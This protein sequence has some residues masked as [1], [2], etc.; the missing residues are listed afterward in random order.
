ME[1]MFLRKSEDANI[2][3]L[4]IVSRITNIKPIENSDKLST[5]I[6]NGYNIIV[7]NTTKIGDIVVF[8]PQESCIC[9]QFL[10]ANNEYGISDYEKNTNADEIKRLIEL[11]ENETDENKAKELM[12]EAKSKVGF[13]NKYGRVTMLK[14][15]GE[16]SFGFIMPINSIEKA[17]P[18]LVGTNW[19][20][21]VGT[22]FNYI[23]D[24]LFCWKY[25]PRVKQ[26]SHSTKG[27]K[28]SR[29]HRRFQ[30]RMQSFDRIIPE[31]FSRH[32]ETEQ[33]EKSIRDIKPDDVISITVKLH[34]QSGIFC[35]ILCNRQLTR[36]EKIKKFFGFDV[37]TTEYGN[38][39]SS[40][41]VIKNKEIN[42]NV[43][44]GY[45]E[46]D[47]WYPV[48][49]M[50]KPYIT[51]G[52]SVYGEVVGY[53]DGTERPIQPDHDYGCEIGEWKFLPY[54]IS[55][56]L[57]DGKKYEWNVIEVDEWT[58]KLLK[59]HPELSKNIIPFELLYHGK[60]KDLYPELDV[61]SE[62][63]YDDVLFKMKSEKKW[64]M[65]EKEPLCHKYDKKIM[66]K[67]SELSTC[68]VGSKKYKDIKKELDKLVEKQAPREGVVI[69]ID[70][71][72]FPRAWKL[73]TAKHYELS[74]KAHDKGEIDMEEMDGM[75]IDDIE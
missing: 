33:I 53:V 48:N 21:L 55:T 44:P 11:S 32:Y 5:T 61:N 27:E 26:R 60:F 18:E 23:G 29:R 2:N 56:A 54:R 13:F 68:K 64:H 36:W 7:Q 46:K 50:L 69:R 30:K 52:M 25:I 6:L 70:N 14:L 73:K 43:T 72:I 67:E 1:T 28:G 9:E 4:A 22:E 62:T 35:N 19:D 66:E 47:T 34:G 58:K 42:K 37:A 63:W 74:K 45:Y 24:T 49:E 16:Y 12:L 40:R 38:V 31:M 17:F 15:R 57:N 75:D 65:E 8:F 51:E 10:S 41:N 59:E 39:Y 71:D 20:E 3:Y